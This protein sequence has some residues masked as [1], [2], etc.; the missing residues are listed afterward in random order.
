[1][2]IASFVHPQFAKALTGPEAERQAIA[3]IASLRRHSMLAS[4]ADEVWLVGRART[5]IERDQLFDDAHFQGFA[6]SVAEFA[7]GMEQDAVA[8]AANPAT[9][10]PRHDEGDMGT[11]VS[12]GD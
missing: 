4:L 7:D 9:S 1:M 2:E 3:E 5:M 11:E 10:Q 6:E 12:D 8:L